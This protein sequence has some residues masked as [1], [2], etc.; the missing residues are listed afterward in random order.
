MQPRNPNDKTFPKTV[1]LRVSII[2]QLERLS[3]ALGLSHGEL[4]TDALLDWFEKQ[5]TLRLSLNRAAE[6]AR[7][8]REAR[9]EEEE[10]GD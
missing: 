7:T 1:H 8:E 6:Y 4:I 5:E 2:E 10:S 3:G 9:R